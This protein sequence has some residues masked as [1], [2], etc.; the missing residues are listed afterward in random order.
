M[1]EALECLDVLATPTIAAPAASV[2]QENIRLGDSEGS[3]LVAYD[4]F[5]FPSNL[6]GSP[7]IS[8][9][10]GF[11]SDGL[12]IGLQ[13]IGKPFDERGLLDVAL[14]YEGGTDWHLRR[15]PV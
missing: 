11:S 1:A 9:P 7:A 13:L 10:C 14:A 6:D 2:G 8:I 15:P 3:V 4:R 5:V 12:P